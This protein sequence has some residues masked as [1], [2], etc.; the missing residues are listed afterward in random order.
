MDDSKKTVILHVRDTNH[1]GTLQ[2]TTDGDDI[3]FTDVYRAYVPF[4]GSQMKLIE[5]IALASVSVALF[6]R[7]VMLFR[8]VNKFKKASNYE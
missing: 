1:D 2:M 4:T 8:N 3:F 6:V 7:M 5:I